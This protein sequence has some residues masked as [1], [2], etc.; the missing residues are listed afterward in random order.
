MNKHLIRLAIGLTLAAG[1][2]AQADINE[3]WFGPSLARNGSASIPTSATYTSN[4]GVAFVA[5]AAGDN[6]I[7]WLQFGLSTSNQ[8]VGAASFKVE[9]RNTTNDIPYSAV[10]GSTSYALD[11]VS[12]SMPTTTNTS[13]SLF[14]DST[15][16]PNISGYSFVEGQSYALIVYNS[17]PSIALA[18]TTGLAE[19]TT[20][21]FY[22]TSYGYQALDTF[23]N[24]TAN[25]TN[26]PGSYVTF[27]IAFGST[28]AVPE[29]SSAAILAGL[30]CLTFVTL[31]RRPAHKS[32]LNIN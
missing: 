21:N 17:S 4:L 13:F 19:N 18:R 30:G 5:G 16:I 9:L 20:N 2:C 28:S 1:T 3:T 10:A 24:N 25:Y 31:V 26:S 6:S 29:P 11:T 8:T 15:D 22:T 7:N 12:F 14:L 27:D 32:R 23:R